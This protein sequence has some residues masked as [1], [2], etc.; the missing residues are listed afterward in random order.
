PRKRD[1]GEE[2]G[3]RMAG[4][5]II[6]YDL[7]KD[8]CRVSY[9]LEGEDAPADFSFSD[10]K[11]PHL[12]QNAICKK[13]DSEE[14][15][16]GQEAYRMALLGGGSVVN[17]L[18]PLVEKKGS[19]T[20]YGVQ[21]SAEELLYQYLSESLKAV[22]EALGVYEIRQ[23]VFSVQELNS[24]V[25]DTIVA[26]MKRMGV[27]RKRIHIISH[28][29]SFLYFVLAQKRDLWSNLSVLYDFSGDG[30]NYYE[31]EILRGMQP[32][33]AYAK[34]KFME[35][36]FSIDILNTEAGRKMADS[37]FTTCVDRMLS[38][39]L[40]SSCYLSGNGMDDCEEWGEHFLKTLCFRRRVFMIEN[41]FAAG[42]VY[43]A[44]EH[45]KGSPLY[46]FSIMCE[47]RINVD[48]T[49]EVY[50]GLNQQTLTLASVGSNWYET[51]A[52]FDIIPDQESTLKLKVKKVGERSPAI[53][54]IPFGELIRR[55][56][57]VNRVGVSL[58]FTEDNSF[59]VTL[60]DRG[61]GEFYAPSDA[62]V[63]RSYTVE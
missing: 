16:V 4:G 49:M 38:K 48:I 46:P 37:I 41:L 23:I 33:V 40:V 7:C 25:L 45:E 32:N 2:K 34:R 60:T 58:Q 21:Y 17:K 6:G 52:E 54:D 59:T 29:E 3:D 24:V 51:R 50:K 43:A 15:L 10:E 26:A 57:K 18:L 20:F 47:G 8:Y 11:N 56:N 1:P 42:A 19:A 35:E 55:P 28:T 14:W 53:V 12:I 22:F 62:M 5:L 44:I 39:K 27:D 61:F 9:Y 63:R 30:L 36:G 31:M 13:K